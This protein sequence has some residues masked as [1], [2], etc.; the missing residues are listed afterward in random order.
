MKYFALAMSLVYVLFG[1]LFLFTDF[2]YWQIMRYR[3]PLGLVLLGYGILRTFMWRRKNMQS[4]EE[5]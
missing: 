2:L 4:Q 1:C 3:V 5:Q